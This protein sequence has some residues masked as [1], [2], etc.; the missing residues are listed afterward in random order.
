MAG[1]A[2]VRLNPQQEAAVAH[3][4]GPML[5]RAGAGTGKTA[6]LVE[7]IARLIAQGHAHPDEIVATTYTLKA[8]GEIDQRV[9]ERVEEELG[10]GSADG[11]RV[12]NFHQWCERLL[13]KHDASFQLLT[14]EQLYV[15]LRQQI[16]A[17]RLPLRHFQKAASPG[18]F[19]SDMLEFI[20]RCQD[21]LV[22]AAG[23]RAYVN[24]LRQPDAVL[25]RFFRSKEVDTISREE[26]IARCEE[27]A[28]VYE[29]VEQI[30]AERG[31]GSFG[32]LIVRALTLLKNNAAVLEGE[33]A[34]SRFI[35][36]DEFQDSN[37]AQL[38]L[39][40]L[41]TVG[42]KNIF[43]VGDPDQAIYRFRGASSAAFQSF[44]TRFPLAK[45][46][47][48][49]E[50]FRSYGHILACA[51]GVIK[52]NVERDTASYARQPLRA[53][54][55]ETDHKVDLVVNEA[56]EAEACEVADAIQA[57]VQGGEDPE[58][59]A[60]LYRQHSHRAEIVKE[61][62]RRGIPF[63]ISGTDLF[64]TDTLRD[65]VAFLRA[66]DSATDHISLFRLAMHPRSGIDLDDL[67]RRLRFSDRER[68]VAGALQ[69]I[70]AGKK[71][72]RDLADLQK[73][74]APQS[75]ETLDI[76]DAVVRLMGLEPDALEIEA[77]RKFIREWGDLCFTTSR[78]LDA[79]LHYLDY[80]Q[81]AGGKL[82]VE[83]KDQ[84]AVQ[85]TT[86]HSAKGLEYRHVYIVRVTTSSFPG[87]YR[88]KL[89]EF[90]EALRVASMF[91]ADDDKAA[92]DEEERR[93]FYVA[94]TRARDSLALHGKKRKGKEPLPPGYMR[95]IGNDKT[96][97]AYIRPRTAVFR[98]DT[99]AA[100]AE[101]EDEGQPMQP[102]LFA[103]APVRSLSASAIDMYA[104]CPLK[105]KFN[106]EDRIP[107]EAGA[108]LQYGA[109][110]HRVLHD[111]YQ[112]VMAKRPPDELKIIERF[113]KEMRE[114]RM[115]DP[116]QYELYEEQGVQQLK[117]FLAGSARA[118]VDVLAT[119]QEFEVMVE[120]VPIRGRIDRIDRLGGDGLRILD[121]KTGAPKDEKAAEESLQLGL[122]AIAAKEKYGTLPDRV[123]FHN[124]EN[125]TIVEVAPEESL[126][127]KAREAVNKAADG[128]SKG[129]FEPKPGFAC[130]YCAY[131]ILC[132]A[133]AERIYTI[134]PAV[135]SSGA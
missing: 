46:V 108:A 101:G 59:I 129:N 121:Y 73:R 85:L 96:L 118:K 8:V 65:I 104:T 78:L 7:R 98:L 38:E 103:S 74:Y 91:E 120:G 6:V 131:S 50:N 52:G 67:K 119:E 105:F 39:A 49:A 80:F 60:V 48:L 92:H 42:E 64:R 35:L 26:I 16:D 43:A 37:L 127:K 30:L 45:T 63:A 71:L 54:R 126:L 29:C 41:L 2:P 130:K 1:K 82:Q 55:G 12:M 135:K 113:R 107:D 62:E 25:P 124:L 61:L 86:V 4:T 53:A 111:Y 72:L 77:M 69:A 13:K 79:F 87:G 97:K 44:M 66:L 128:I 109:A 68:G 114:A 56:A 58:Q 133:T 17:K 115:E 31:T 117:A 36:I 14:P 83:N 23:Y 95:E 9:R 94:V 123:A 122:Y 102:N 28:D 3:V 100:S 88:R 33:R 134:A 93:L 27:V 47:T 21:E 106:R 20:D 40:D 22:D 116:L 15:L 75:A 89:F 99:V 10:P 24:T 112:A 51:H 11:I 32:Q 18:K 5:V 90:P 34:H 84:G 125:D 57:L 70:P 19:L 81:E 110:V 132:P 76:F